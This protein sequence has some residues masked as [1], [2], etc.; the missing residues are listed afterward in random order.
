M[1]ADRKDTVGATLPPHR[2]LT[3]FYPASAL[4]AR[5]VSD[6]FD[7]AAR[8]YDWMSG[9]MSFGT[10]RQY[11]RHA[12][13]RAG[14]KP[15]LRVLDV[16]T[17]TGLVA[18]AALDLGISPGNLIGLDPSRGML[19]ENRKR[20]AFQLVQGF[21]EALPFQDSTFDFVV[22]GYALRH[23]EDLSALF[24]EFRRVL[25]EQGRVLILEIT[26]P[27]SRA[28]LGLMRFYMRGLLPFLTRLSTRHRDSARL[29]EYY[30]ATI[31]ECVP[32]TLILS[33]LSGAG[34]KDVARRACGR[35]L[36]EYRGTRS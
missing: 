28:G 31:A 17:G 6:L 21:G 12:L 2:P 27:S 25:S 26:R 29:M 18:Q 34:F 19:E 23:V 1:T 36:S 15:G 20:R 30:W 33:A 32:P 3:E 13:R 7:R 4:R 11:R 9:L 14:L 22:M 5:Y 35:I 8:D 10:D 24:A 16:A